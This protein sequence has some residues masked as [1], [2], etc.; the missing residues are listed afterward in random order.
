MLVYTI[1]DLIV[2]GLAGIG[3]SLIIIFWVL[4]LIHQISCKHKDFY[5]NGVTL[6][7]ICRNCGKNF[8][9]AGSEENKELRKRI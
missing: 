1:S 8:G 3:I 4:T 2:L 5:K 7:L 6:D 9:F